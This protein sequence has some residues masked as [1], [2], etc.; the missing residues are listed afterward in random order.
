MVNRNEGGVQLRKARRKE[1][2]SSRCDDRTAQRAFPTTDYGSA[3]QYKKRPPR[4]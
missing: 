4:R 2:G 1:V 3:M